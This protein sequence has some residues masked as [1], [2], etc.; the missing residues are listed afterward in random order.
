MLIIMI[1][2]THHVCI[3]RMIESNIKRSMSDEKLDLSC[4]GDRIFNIHV[5]Q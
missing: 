4:L 2:Y 3:F 5:I 1:D